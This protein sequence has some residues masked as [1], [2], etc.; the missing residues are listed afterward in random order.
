MWTALRRAS[1][2]AGTSANAL[3]E[4][5]VTRCTGRRAPAGPVRRTAERGRCE[6]QRHRHGLGRGSR[7]R[8]A[9]P[10]HH[11]LG[12][13]RRRPDR[14]GERAPAR[15][16][17]ARVGGRPARRHDQL[18][19]RDPGLVSLGGVP[20]RGGRAR[21]RRPRPVAGR[22]VH[23]RSRRRHASERR[24][25]ADERP[26]RSHA[27]PSSARDSATRRSGARS[28]PPRLP[29]SSRRSATSAA[30]GRRRSTSP[31][32]RAGG[33]TAST[34]PGSATGIGPPASCLSPRRGA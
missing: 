12:P 18:P 1:R 9:A 17:R 15:H 26:R 31:G 23:G 11:H 33:W 22:D 21:G 20:R 27:R 19:L 2:L 10:R 34:R 32:S 6:E 4:L 16:D 13:A 25:R 7:R 30:R 8:A 24:T 28:R 14:G 5:A 29:M 3:R